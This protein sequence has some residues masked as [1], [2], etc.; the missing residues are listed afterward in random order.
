MTKIRTV[1]QL[2]DRLS[3]EIAWR[4]KELIYIKTLIEREKKISKTIQ[5][6]LLTLY[7]NDIPY[8]DYDY[9]LHKN[10]N[11]TVY[12]EHKNRMKTFCT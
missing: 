7:K 2:S 11:I 6:T 5:T 4:K 10:E 3:E 1:S 9:W 8:L 12:L